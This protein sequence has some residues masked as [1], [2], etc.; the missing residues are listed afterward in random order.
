MTYNLFP[1]Q[2]P[3]MPTVPKTAKNIDFLLKKRVF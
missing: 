1:L 3:M 2:A